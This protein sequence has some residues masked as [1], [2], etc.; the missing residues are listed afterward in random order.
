MTASATDRCVAA[1]HAV[2]L[3]RN[4]F[5]SAPQFLVRLVDIAAMLR[6]SGKQEGKFGSI[7]ICV[8]DALCRA[9]LQCSYEEAVQQAKAQQFTPSF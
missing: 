5:S 8:A 4:H 1:L 6:S 2:E 7:E 3:A 9:H